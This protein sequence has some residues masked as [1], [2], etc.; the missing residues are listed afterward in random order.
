MDSA[1]CLAWAQARFSK[2]YALTIDYGQKHFAELTAALHVA[3]AMGV[4]GNQHKLSRISAAT[5]DSALVSGTPDG[6]HPSN[7]ALPATFTPGRNAVFLSVAAGVAYSLNAH[8]IVIGACETDDA[9]Y[10]DCRAP[11]LAAMQESLSLALDTQIKIHAPLLNKSKAAIWGMAKEYG[12]H[13]IIDKHS[14]TCYRNVLQG[15]GEC[16]ACVLRNNGR[17]EAVRLGLL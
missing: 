17:E 2:V 3:D 7:D 16:A 15:C 12:V 11:F 5:G 1:V 6:K 9:G 13:E 10:P 14:H 8:N 4:P